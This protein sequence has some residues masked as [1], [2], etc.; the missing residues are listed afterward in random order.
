MWTSQQKFTRTSSQPSPP[1]EWTA[2]PTVPLL[3]WV[4]CAHGDAHEQEIATPMRVAHYCISRSDSPPR[5]HPLEWS[6]VI[7]VCVVHASLCRWQCEAYSRPSEPH[8]CRRRRFLHWVRHTQAPDTQERHGPHR[9]TH[10][11]FVASAKQNACYYARYLLF[12]RNFHFK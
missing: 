4:S 12:V 9:W 2:P 10:S 8:T 3:Y 1:S 7:C 6:T 11:P 5:R